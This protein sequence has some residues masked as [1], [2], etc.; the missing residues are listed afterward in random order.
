MSILEELAKNTKPRFSERV[1]FLKNR[2]GYD[3]SELERRVEECIVKIGNGAKSFVVYGEPQSG[4]TE[5]MI[6][7]TCKLLDEGFE[8]I[9]VLV[10]DNLE[11]EKQNY[12]RFLRSR[13]LKPSPKRDFD[14]TDLD[15]KHRKSGSK[16][17]IFCRKNSNRLE[18]LLPA[19]KLMRKRV[20]IDD[21]ADYASP[22]SNINQ[23]AKATK[24]NALVKKL[25]ETKRDKGIYIGITATPARLDLNNTFLNDSRNWVF[26]APHKSYVG[27]RYFFPESEEDIMKSNYQPVKLSE[28]GDGRNIYEDSIIRYLVRASFL[29][30]ESKDE[31][32]L[33]YTFLIHSSGAVKDHYKDKEIIDD[34][35]AALCDRK[36]KRSE[37]IYI[38]IEEQAE[39][40]ASSES[41]TK[42]SRQATQHIYDNCELNDVL[43]INHKEDKGNALRACNPETLFTF[44]IG[45]NIVSRGLTFNNLLTFFF[46]RNVKDKLTHNTYIQRARMFGTRPYINHFELAVPETLFANWAE[47][48]YEH[49]MAL[50]LLKEHGIYLH[51]QSTKTR[52]IDSRSIDQNNVLSMKGEIELS[53]IFL[54]TEEN[55][56]ILH[57]RSL[58]TLERIEKLNSKEQV[59]KKDILS[60]LI[61]LA[62]IDPE[63]FGMVFLSNGR[64]LLVEDYKDSVSE[65]L[66]RK[67]GG[68]I[69][70]AIRKNPIYNEY[71]HLIMPIKNKKNQAKLL[72]KASVDKSF[73]RNIINLKNENK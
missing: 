72:Y 47:C 64:I 61:K 60:Y 5:F 16:R 63:A 1:S 30:L 71:T 53:D 33:G 39:I 42:T 65:T 36:S 9:F 15:D 41:F 27:H 2:K 28:I 10:N 44:A 21:E 46:S 12:I 43:I 7:L 14:I 23:N 29:D 11:L 52:A 55:N 51:I 8:T 40:I 54:L 38:K 18:N 50:S 57:D 20:V 56:S 31:K 45:G 26:L 34:F 67:R 58:R 69:Q 48:F 24:I 4:K 3:T 70:G 37:N 73:M 22:N 49:E 25:I 62:A 66:E 17:I 32:D 59:I 35:L 13:Q 19:T 68:L 6:A